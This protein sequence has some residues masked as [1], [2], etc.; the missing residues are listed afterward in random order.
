MAEFIGYTIQKTTD[1][2]QDTKHLS[3]I[4]AKVG[5]KVNLLNRETV[6]L[7]T[8][9]IDEKKFDTVVHRHAGRNKKNLNAHKTCEVY[10]YAQ[11]HTAQETA[12]YCGISL[13][14]YQR[15]LKSEREHGTWNTD[16][17]TYFGA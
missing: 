3:E 13:R 8:F 10:Q 6:S 12:D 14:T 17:E 11:T 5:I 7:L 4:L 1:T 16:T 2:E 15:R 9:S